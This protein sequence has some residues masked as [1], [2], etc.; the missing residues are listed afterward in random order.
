MLPK[1]LILESEWSHYIDEKSACDIYKSIEAMP[2]SIDVVS[3]PLIKD[4][5]LDYIGQFI[6]LIWNKAETNVIILSGHGG[7]K[8]EIDDQGN[9]WHRREISGFT[10]QIDL[11]EDLEE[12]EYW[13]EDGKKIRGPFQRT[14]FIL[15][16]CLIGKKIKQ[17]CKQVDAFGVIGYSESVDWTDSSIFTLAILLHFLAAEVFTKQARGGNPLAK[18]ILDEMKQGAYKSMMEELGV[19]YAFRE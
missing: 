1:I 15:D 14:I 7:N 13:D 4:I 19:T 5:Y 11:N 17:F 6:S 12:F 18:Q 8:T 10:G 2:Y 3:R 9:R 16:S